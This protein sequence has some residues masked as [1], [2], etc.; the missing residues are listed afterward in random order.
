MVV[1]VFYVDLD[2]CA[3][4]GGEVD[5]AVVD[6]A[7]A[8]AFDLLAYVLE[9]GGEGGG[10]FGLVGLVGGFEGAEEEVGFRVGDAV[11]VF[12]FGLASGGGGAGGDG[13]VGV[14]VAGKW[15]GCV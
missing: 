14:D 7:V 11:E 9:V 12:V 4:G 2:A 10:V 15:E 13:V 5:L 8:A 1:G 3:G 6:D